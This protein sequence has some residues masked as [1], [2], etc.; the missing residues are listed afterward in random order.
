MTPA[1]KSSGI[2]FP[3]GMD[4]DS[5]D[6]DIASKLSSEFDVSSMASG[7]PQLRGKKFKSI[8]DDDGSQYSSQFDKGS[9]QG[10]FFAGKLDKDMQTDNDL[11]PK[12]TV[13][14]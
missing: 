11:V 5:S 13:E 7:I 10:D 2:M 8:V 6:E 3:G 1:Q 14:M 9:E 12:V 4:A